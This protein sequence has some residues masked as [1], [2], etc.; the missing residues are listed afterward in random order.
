MKLDRLSVYPIWQHPAF[1]TSAQAQFLLLISSHSP[2]SH[3][4]SSVLCSINTAVKRRF[5]T[6]P[7]DV[8]LSLRHALHAKLLIFAVLFVN[9]VTL[10]AQYNHPAAFP[11]LLVLWTMRSLAWLAESLL[12][13]SKKKVLGQP[14]LCIL[15]SCW[16]ER[17][18]APLQH[19]CRYLDLPAWRTRRLH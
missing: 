10:R 3:T 4:K 19:E 12:S 8:I 9:I 13:W 1:A 18:K 14:F 2:F 5:E 7:S 6:L 11:T 17:K 15:R 16:C